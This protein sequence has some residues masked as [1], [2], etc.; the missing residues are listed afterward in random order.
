MELIVVKDREQA[1]ELY[2]EFRG[3]IAAPYTLC[4]YFSYSTAGMPRGIPE[5]PNRSPH[6]AE[7]ILLRAKPKI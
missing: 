5:N 6:L 3:E 7:V 1:L 2:A 4:S